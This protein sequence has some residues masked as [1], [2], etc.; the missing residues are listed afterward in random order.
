MFKRWSKSLSREEGQSLVIIAFALIGLLAFLGLVIDGGLAFALRRQ[1]QNASDSASLAG[2]RELCARQLRSLTGSADEQA[3]LREVHEFAEKNSVQDSNA[4]PNDGINSNVTAYF[5][6][7]QG[8]RVGT[9]M[10]TNGGIPSGARGVQAITRGSR[11]TLLATFIGQR[12][13]AVAAS[14]IAIC[15]PGF[16]ENFAM[17]ADSQNCQNAINWAGSNNI[18]EGTVHT[19]K[20][21]NMA[22]SNNII[23][24]DL[25]YVES[26]HISGQNN[27]YNPVQVS[28]GS[29]DPYTLS[30]YAPGGPAAQIAQ[31]EGR[32]YFYQGDLHIR[33]ND[34]FGDGLYYVTGN[35]SIRS[36][37][38]SGRVTIVAQGTIDISGSDH[39][40]ST[41]IDGLLLFSNYQFEQEGQQCN[42]PV[43]N[44][45]GGQNIWQGIIYAPH[46]QVNLSA[47]IND[48]SIRGSII[49]NTINLAASDTTISFGP[50]FVPNF[51]HLIQ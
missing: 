47:S 41:Y 9:E 20:D 24:Q 21:L 23:T 11:P 43:I 26:Y 4:A 7:R 44:M 13:Q 35:V 22:G 8:N 32:Y 34:T 28:A 33:P 36:N 1:L 3:V 19:N 15:R 16:V 25:E 5:V 17:W 18:A 49:A 27:V 46:G 48:G 50:E 51:F 42:S 10:G 14:A 12:I 29:L 40:L 6:N 39:N 2:T 38:P 37:N 30:D 45:S 31:A